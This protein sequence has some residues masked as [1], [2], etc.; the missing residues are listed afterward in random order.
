MN[1]VKLKNIIIISIMLLITARYLAAG[2]NRILRNSNSA[3]GDQAAYLQLGLDVREHGQLTDGKRNPL[4]PVILASFAQREWS[5]FTWAKILNFAV[6]LVT[7]WA[8]FL[9]GRRLFEPVTGVVAAL[10]LSINIEFIAHATFALAESLLILT[11]L[12]AWYAMVRALKEPDHLSY[13]VLGGGLA[14]LAYLAKGTGPLIAICFVLTVGLL[15]GYRIFTRRVFWSFVVGFVVISLPLWLYNWANFGSPIFNSAVNN[16]MWMDSATEKYVAD[17]SNLPTFSTY[18]Q[19]K[20]LGEV[21]ERLSEGLLAMRYYFARLLWP[22]RSLI[23]DRYFQAGWI[24]LI[25]LSVFILAVL[26]MKFL[27]PVFRRYREALLLTAV[28]VLVFYFL[29]G[30][31]IA[32]S[33]FPIRFILP[34]APVLFL[35]LSAGAV[36]L[37]RAVFAAPRVP[38]WTKVALAIAVFVVVLRPVGWFA[39][40]GYLI[41]SQ[42]LQNAF[43]ADAEFNSYTEQ[44]LRW[45]RSGHEEDETVTVMW[46]PTHMLPVWRHSDTL[47]LLRTPVAEA[48]NTNDLESFMATNDVAYIVVDSEMVSRMGRDHAAKWGISTLD[49]GRVE[50]GDYPSDWALGFAGPEMPCQWCVFRRLDATPIINAIDYQLGDSIILFGYELDKADYVAGGQLVV[51]LYWQAEQSVAGNYTVFTQLLGPDYQLHG[52]MDRPP[53]SGVWPTGRWLPQQK[54]VDKFILE[55]DEAAPA[56]DYV[57][58]VGLYDGNT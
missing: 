50:L 44:S 58:L 33:P 42:S 38:R 14:G 34:V 10:L 41:V 9:I 52:Q 36:G 27:A 3:D 5:Y 1:S 28:M 39:V 40:S 6:G 51:T 55:I 49:N 23:F 57:L 12:L 13:W 22:T 35:L 4:F 30:W 29:F 8:V 45:V 48:R 47:N 15:F 25:F 20:S 54:F 21:W 11:V 53:L 24:D 56:G 46:G 17:T 18:F 19:D 43:R 26:S 2:W 16:V 32:I 37:L 7:I 31:Y